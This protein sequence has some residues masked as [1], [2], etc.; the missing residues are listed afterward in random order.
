LNIRTSVFPGVAAL[1]REGSS[2]SSQPTILQY[3]DNFTP[4]TLKFLLT[5][6]LMAPPFP[7]PVTQLLS[8]TSWKLLLPMFLHTRTT[9]TNTFNMLITQ[10]YSF[11]LN[12]GLIV[13]ASHRRRQAVE[14]ATGAAGPTKRIAGGDAVTVLLHLLRRT[15]Q[16]CSLSCAQFSQSFINSL[17]TRGKPTAMVHGGDDGSAAIVV[18]LVVAGGSPTSVQPWNRARSV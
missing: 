3:R 14:T 13:W 5:F 16:R 9:L 18:V 12:C 2:I 1:L 7:L 17:L 10:F 6:L 4:L 15:L 8:V 11:W